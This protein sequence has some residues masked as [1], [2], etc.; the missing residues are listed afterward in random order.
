M[1]R[2]DIGIVQ[3]LPVGGS[4]PGEQQQVLTVN[5]TGPL[6]TGP[7]A[8]VELAVT[9]FVAPASPG[10]EVVWSV[11]VKTFCSQC[12]AENTMFNFCN[13]CG[14]PKAGGLGNPHWQVRSGTCVP[15]ACASVGAS[16]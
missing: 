16:G 8:A 5:H 3:T 14:T 13:S 11:P 10:Q 7:L 2:A 6:P 4:S 9:N 1:Q 12:G 15:S